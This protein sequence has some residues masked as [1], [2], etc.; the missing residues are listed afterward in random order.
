[1]FLL[2]NLILLYQQVL[3][4]ILR[5]ILLWKV[6]P[7]QSFDK[8]HFDH[9]SDIDSRDFINIYQEC[10]A[11]SY[12]FLVTDTS[13]VSNNLLHLRRK[14]IRKNIKNSHVNWG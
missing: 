14:T 3:D 11:K 9:L 2:H 4:K 5:V 1:M 6:Q 12:L 13:L 10:T 7:I 8:S